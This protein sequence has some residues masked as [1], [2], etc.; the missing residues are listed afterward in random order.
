MREWRVVLGFVER[1]VAGTWLRTRPGLFCRGEGRW[2]VD[3]CRWPC[4]GQMESLDGGK[5]AGGEWSV[6]GSRVIGVRIRK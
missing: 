3:P 2:A 5:L 4:C 6:G 1:L